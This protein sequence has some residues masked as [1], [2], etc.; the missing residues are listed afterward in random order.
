MPSVPTAPTALV[1]VPGIDFGRSSDSQRNEYQDVPDRYLYYDLLHVDEHSDVLPTAFEIAIARLK[2]AERS[3]SHAPEAL[4]PSDYANLDH[5]LGEIRGWWIRKRDQLARS[6]SDVT[7]EQCIHLLKQFAPSALLDG[8]WLQNV[9]SAATSHT[10]LTAGLLKLYAQ[11]IG[12]GDPSRHHGN[13]FRDLTRSLG[14]YLPEVG[15]FAFVEQRDVT[16]AAFR[17]PVFLL[18]ISQ[19]PRM[20]APEI[21]GL[22]LFYY[23]CGICPLYPALRDRLERFGASSRFLDLH[24][25]GPAIA[26]PAETAVGMIKHSMET[27]SESSTVGD[28]RHWRRIIRGFN[29]AHLASIDQMDRGL[30]FVHSPSKSP[31]EQMVEL[32]T[33]KARHAHGYHSETML[34]GRSLDDWL[35]PEQ[36]EPLE[37]LN[38][39]ARSPSVKP[40]DAKGSLFFQRLVA[41]RGPMFRIFSPDELRVIAGW[42][43]SLPQGPDPDNSTSLVKLAHDRSRDQASL[44]GSSPRLRGDRKELDHESIKRYSKKPL[45]ELYYYLL[46]IE[47]FPDVRPFAKRF[48]TRWLHQAGR[49]LSRGDRPLPFK[50]FRQQALDSWLDAQHGRQVES[51]RRHDGEPAQ[52]REELIESTVQLA[53]MILIDGAWIQNAFKASTSHTQVGSKLFHTYFDEVGN[54]EVTLN[55][56]NVYRE[57]LA[58]MGVQ[59][60]EF[61]TLEF[62]QWPGFLPDAF[63]VPVFWLCI[64]QFPK[65]F[66]SETLGLNLAMELSGVGGAYRSAIDT[67]RYYGYDPCFV[68]LHNTIDNVSTGH[69][70]W[71]VETIKCHMDEMFDRGG[72]ELVEEVWERVWTGYRALAP[73]TTKL[74]RIWSSLLSWRDD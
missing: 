47:H 13:A 71:A 16:D 18:S 59:L 27:A 38:E 60:P 63:R 52:S 73:Q 54:G 61:G 23:V 62:G 56:P 64:S 34:K 14:I 9:C 10:E 45:G 15:A 69:A 5:R 58:Q 48:A 37:F 39:F 51:Y 8:C 28:D 32:I 65:S 3:D 22:N 26:G 66:L 19:F 74:S 46:N 21:L 68:E 4:G 70:A 50:P 41:F 36:M 53:P 25:L 2:Y 11:E 35:N 43:D 31:R 40:G 20:L 57:L 7:Q 49:G 24:V 1:V 42:I 72:V 29:A 17:D 44:N 55:H 6:L 30:L 33:R 67:L 12:G